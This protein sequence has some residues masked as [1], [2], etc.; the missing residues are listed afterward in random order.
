MPLGLLLVLLTLALAF[1]LSQMKARIGPV[2]RPPVFGPVAAF[3]LTN[4]TVPQSLWPI[5]TG[6]HGSP[7]SFSR[8]AP[9]RACA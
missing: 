5:C 8:G 9:D 1:L 3:T 6:G 4:R 7:T 2:A